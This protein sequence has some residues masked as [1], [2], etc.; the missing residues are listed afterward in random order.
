MIV[1]NLYIPT[2]NRLHQEIGPIDPPTRNLAVVALT[3]LM[4]L[5]V[6]DGREGAIIQ[7]N[8]LWHLAQQ[9]TELGDEAYKQATH[10]DYQ[11]EFL[12]LGKEVA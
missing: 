5:D 4:S 7:A 3:H 12:N 2:H 8:Y 10:L 1:H 11:I 9:D 6:E